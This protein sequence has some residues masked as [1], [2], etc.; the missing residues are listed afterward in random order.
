MQG[1]VTGYV[2]NWLKDELLKPAVAPPAPPGEAPKPP[3]RQELHDEDGAALGV[4][5]LAAGVS[6]YVVSDG[7][8][9]PQSEL[10]RCISDPNSTLMVQTEGGHITALIYVPDPELPSRQSLG[11]RAADV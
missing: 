7:Y 10:A 3:E 2:G 5:F 9:T 4:A 8:G 1:V 6:V 11:L